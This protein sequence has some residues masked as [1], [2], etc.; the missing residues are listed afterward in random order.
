MSSLLCPAQYAIAEE[1]S[2][3]M[4]SYPADLPTAYDADYGPRVG[5]PHYQLWII[6]CARRASLAVSHAPQHLYFPEFKYCTGHPWCRFH[7]GPLTAA[8]TAPL[9]AACT[10]PTAM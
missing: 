9:R 10:E 7:M 2:R 6:R 8:G 1:Y 5:A 3:K 4:R